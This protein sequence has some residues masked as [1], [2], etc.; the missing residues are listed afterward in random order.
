ML[1]LSRFRGALSRLGA[2]SAF[3]VLTACGGGGGMGDSPSASSAPPPSSSSCGSDCNTVFVAMTDADGDFHGAFE[4]GDQ[5]MRVAGLIDIA[6]EKNYL[7]IRSPVDP[8]NANNLPAGTT[9]L[10]GRLANVATAARSSPHC[11]RYPRRGGPSDVRPGG[12]TSSSR[13]WA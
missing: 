1:T 10:F 4:G 6:Q 11:S 2:L 8:N 13:S 9:P 12:P 5:N 3:M 7:K